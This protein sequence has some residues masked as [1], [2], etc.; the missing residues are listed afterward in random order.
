MYEY[1]ISLK[2]PLDQL[3]F[4]RGNDHWF[5]DDGTI[6]KV[7]GDNMMDVLLMP[8][9]NINYITI[10]PVKQLGGSVG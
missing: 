1:T 6:F 3:L 7:V 4:V 9:E 5:I 2:V 8:R 10:D